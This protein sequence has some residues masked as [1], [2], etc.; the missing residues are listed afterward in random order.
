MKA[1]EKKI[2]RESVLNTIS[3][4]PMEDFEFKGFTKEG[5]AFSN[6][7]VV[8]MIKPTIKNDGFDLEAAL[9]GEKQTN[10]SLTKVDTVLDQLME[11][12]L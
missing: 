6:G 8:I 10:T 11:E 12:N 1:S 2:L 5:A 9:A 3:E 4:L 7:E